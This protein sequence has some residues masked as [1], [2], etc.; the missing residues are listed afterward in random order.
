MVQRVETASF[1]ADA[2]ERRATAALT[3]IGK[4]P[5]T[6]LAR[7]FAGQLVPTEA[8]LAR[9]EGR[10]YE[11]ADELLTRISAPGTKPTWRRTRAASAVA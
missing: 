11:S 9:A 1:L 6:I 10:D 8:E 7:A 4:L 2:V 5:R 3:H